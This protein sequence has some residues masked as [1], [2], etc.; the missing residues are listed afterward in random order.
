MHHRFV[1]A[2]LLSALASTQVHA[3]TMTSMISL[4]AAQC[5][6]R[7]VGFQIHNC[8]MVLNTIYDDG[9]NSFAFVPLKDSTDKGSISFLGDG[10]RQIKHGADIAEQPVIG[11]TLTVVQ[12]NGKAESVSFDAVGS[13]KFGNPT[14][15]VSEVSCTANASQNMGTFT[16]NFRSDGAQPKVFNVDHH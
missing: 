11:I 5:E 4:S 1:V 16:G 9:M 2:T 8:S 14:K 13:C 6:S 3:R 12:T 10:K 15:W 7:K